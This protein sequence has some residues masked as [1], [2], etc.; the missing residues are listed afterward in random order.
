[1][2]ERAQ[3]L[4]WKINS[5]K[6]I[7]CMIFYDDVRPLGASR[8]NMHPAVMS[9]RNQY[10]FHTYYRDIHEGVFVVFV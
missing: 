8:R 10:R 5:I 7:Y 4:P 1:M 3:E 9:S 2:L 6:S